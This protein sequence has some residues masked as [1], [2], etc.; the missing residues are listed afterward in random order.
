VYAM[1]DRSGWSLMAVSASYH[2]LCSLIKDDAVPY[3]IAPAGSILEESN[4]HRIDTFSLVKLYENLAGVQWRGQLLLG[5]LRAACYELILARAPEG[6]DPVEIPKN[7]ADTGEKPAQVGNRPKAGTAT[8]MVWDTADR[9]YPKAAEVSKALN[10][11]LNWRSL[12]EAV[13]EQLPEVNP[14][15]VQ[16]QFGKWKASKLSE[17]GS[18]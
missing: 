6:A 7:S 15:T 8:G 18:N 3:A 9:L 14:A 10:S 4:I 12:L 17:L 5:P 13:R 11:Q 2:Y 16:V 1:I